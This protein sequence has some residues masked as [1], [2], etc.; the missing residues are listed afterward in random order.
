MKAAA[1]VRYSSDN[2]R[3]ESIDAQ[4]RA[5]QEY[6]ERNGIEIVKIYPDEAKSATTDQRPYFLQMM[7]DSE[8]GI[9]QAVIVHKLDR[10]AR[11]RYDSAFYKRQLK[12]N[13]V[14]LISVLE[15]LGDSPESIILESVL[16]GMAEYY[17][18]NLAREVMKGMKETALQA[19]HNG[20]IPP[21]GYNVAKDKTYEVNEGEAVI[22]R[23]IFDMYLEG[24]GYSRIAQVLNEQGYRTK[25]G[26]TF[27]KNNIYDILRNEKYKGTYVFNKRTSKSEGKRN[28]HAY[29]ENDDIVRIPGAMPAIID[30]ITFDKAQEKL[31]GRRSGPRMTGKRYYLLTGLVFC[32]E[33]GSPYTGNGYRHGRGGK[34][35]V[36]YSCTN[37]KNKGNCK[38][39]SIRQDILEQ[40]VINELLNTV[41]S[42]AEI[43]EI[44][45]KII[46]YA[47]NYS[48]EAA[49]ERAYIEDKIKEINNKVNK[50]LD[51]IEEGIADK[52]FTKQRMSQ[53]K[54]ESSQYQQRLSELSSTD[55]SWVNRENIAAY[56]QK[57]KEILLTGEPQEK[58][59][60]IE[61]YVDKVIIY[62]D[63]IDIEFKINMDSDIGGGGEPLL[64]IALSI[65]LSNLYHYTA[66]YP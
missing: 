15:Q 34:K 25:K 24:Y 39:K 20:G 17:S 10:F 42:S 37:R 47:K 13:G 53:Y 38:N 26:N 59:K 57:S 18:K 49:D 22:I 30:E 31:D 64:T 16:E 36:I 44:S 55:Y 7:K 9:F 41:F 58:R 65:S 19:K 2:Q 23:K 8:L 4:I 14:R 12:K 3:E 32:G 48:S 52:E 50:L 66:E 33:C 35:Y 11:N 40:R 46:E 27:S 28:N 56:I 51:A 61:T 63:R 43:E 54:L 62:P 5:I 60:V 1:Y 21:L 29:K 45:D 6:A